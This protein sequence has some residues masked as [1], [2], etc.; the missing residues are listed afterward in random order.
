M[1][2]YFQALAEALQI[3]GVCVQGDKQVIDQYWLHAV[4]SSLKSADCLTRGKVACP[5][6]PYAQAAVEATSA[7]GS[8]CNFTSWRSFWHALASTSRRETTSAV[9]W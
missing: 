5:K 9:L 4:S 2:T 6:K 1:Q 8:G 3:I 7:K